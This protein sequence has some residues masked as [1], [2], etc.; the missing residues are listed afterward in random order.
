M[1][2]DEDIECGG[3]WYTTALGIMDRLLGLSLQTTQAP[4]PNGPQGPPLRQWEPT[5]ACWAVIRSLGPNRAWRFVTGT[6]PSIRDG[7]L[8]RA[9]LCCPAVPRSWMNAYPSS[10]AGRCQM[11]HVWGGGSGRFCPWRTETAVTGHVSKKGWLGSPKGGCGWLVFVTEDERK[12]VASV[13]P[14]PRKMRPYQSRPSTPTAVVVR[15]CRTH[16]S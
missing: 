3:R 13:R 4:C 11:R 6:W 14:K 7:L 8:G 9:S 12:V 5:L 15:P 16:T 1:A 10:V 2:Q